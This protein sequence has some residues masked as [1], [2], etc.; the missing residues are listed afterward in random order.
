MKKQDVIALMAVILYSGH[1]K[2]EEHPIK[3]AEDWYEQ[4]EEW[5][6]EDC[7]LVGCCKAEQDNNSCHH[8]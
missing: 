1:R 5:F 6:K 3:E 4:V 8:N 2:C 7:E